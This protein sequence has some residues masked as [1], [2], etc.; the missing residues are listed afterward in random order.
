V[1][2]LSV[3]EPLTLLALNCLGQLSNYKLS[4][5]YYF[6][7]KTDFWNKILNLTPHMDVMAQDNR[8][9]FWYNSQ[10]FIGY[11]ELFR[12]GDKNWP[13]IQQLFSCNILGVWVTIDGFWIDNCNDW[14]Y[15][16]QL[17]VTIALSL[18]QTLCSSLQYVLSLLSLLCLYQSLPRNGFQRRRS[19]ILHV[20]EFW[21]LFTVTITGVSEL[22][23]LASNCL[24]QTNKL[25]GLSPRANY[26][27]WATGSCRRSDCQRLRRECATWS[28]WWIPTAVFSVL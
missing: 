18:R 9:G 4:S 26:T 1:K 12:C 6:G 19:I 27:D 5:K 14:T 28:A 13:V 15:N 3:V 11:F 16:S 8:C 21:S 7:S 24:K 17:Q 20:N 10:L 2:P 25:H 23:C 22:D